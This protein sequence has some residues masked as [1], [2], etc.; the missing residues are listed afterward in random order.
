MTVSH[1]PAPAAKPR[2]AATAE[3]LMTVAAVT[4][5]FCSPAG[6]GAKFSGSYRL[7]RFVVQFG[8]LAAAGV[9]TGELTSVDGTRVGMG[10]HRQTTAIEVLAS[11]TGP[12][13]QLGPV[14]VPLL[15]FLVT[16]NQ[17]SI[18]M[19]EGTYQRAVHEALALAEA[20]LDS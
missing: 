3:P 1:M 13:I 16:I 2:T 20:R 12:V 8:L 18:N 14:D 11:K 19:E 4:G 10:S 6:R 17:I 5:S 7:E 9:F 15:G